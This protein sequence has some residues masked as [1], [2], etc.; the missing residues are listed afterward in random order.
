M[1]KEKVREKFGSD[2]HVNE[3][4]YIMG[5]DIR[6][7]D[8]LAKRF[9]NL[10]VLETCS[11]GGFT[12]ISLAKYAKKV[13]SFEINSKRINEAKENAK[14]AKVDSN[15]TF[16][17]DDINN[18]FQYEI[19]SL[20]DGVFIDP[21]WAVTGNDHKYKFIDSNTKPPSDALL[22]RMLSITPNIT[23]I[24]PP[25]INLK[26]FD[27]LP[28]HE[29]EYLFMEDSLELYSLHFGKL[30]KIVGKSNFMI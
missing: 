9:K 11:G 14:I 30:T 1:N 27:A 25:Y 24:Q 26:E 2:Y 23:L 17:N 28:P 29:I 4:T 8:H 13:Y 10:T 16:I 7:T 21:D 20:I 22:N 19:P 18:I 15:I 12:T 3:D 5:I 6:F